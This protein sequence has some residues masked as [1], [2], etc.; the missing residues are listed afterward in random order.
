[1]ASAQVLRKQEH[2]EAGK[3]RLE[4]FRKKKA[5][6]QVKKAASVSQ[7]HTSDIRPHQKQPLE[8]EPVRRTDSDGAGTSDE[9]G[10]A[11]MGPS[12]AVTANENK[13]I[14][15]PFKSEQDSLNDTL[16]SPPLSV[17]YSNAHYAD[18]AQTD[19]GDKKFKTYGASGFA[20]SMDVN[21]SHETEGL[22]NDVGIYTGV[23]GKLP[24][25]TATDQSRFFGRDGSQSTENRSS[26]MQ[27]NVTNPGYS[28]DSTAKASPQNS[29]GT[30]RQANPSNASMLISAHTSSSFYEDSIQATSNARG[31]AH[32]T[33][34]HM[35]GISHIGDS[36]VSD[37]EE[38][39]LSSYASSLPS[40]NNAAPL[41]FEATGTLF[42]HTDPEK[43]SFMSNSSNTNNMDL[44]GSSAF[45]KPSV[46]SESMG[47]F[48]KLKTPNGPSVFDQSRNSS[49]YSGSGEDPVR[50]SI[51]ENNLDIKQEFY[52]AKQNEDFAALEQHIEDLTQEK[53]SLQRALEASQAL[54]E[55][56]ASEN[57]SATDSYNQQ[58]S[59]VNQLKSDMEKLQEE[60]KAQLVELESVKIE[61]SNA[62]LECNAADE[63]AKLL[64]AEVIG[65]EEKALRLRSSELKLERQLEKS[66]AEI[67]SY[68]KKMSSL[69][70]ERQDLQ[71]TIDALQEEKKL[72]QSKLRKA[73][74]SN[75]SL[76]K[77]DTSTST[78]DLEPS[79]HET[80]QTASS[81]GSDASSVSLLPENGQ[82]TLEVS[83]VNIPSDQMRMI[84]NINAIISELALEKEELMQALVSESS[85]CSK[86]KELN[87]DLSHKLES[88]TQRLEL[89]TA[90]SM[91][92]ESIQAR[93]PDSHTMQENTPY[94]DEG[95]EVVERV[96]G[97]IM[98]LFP[99]GPSRRR[100]SKLL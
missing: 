78:E 40:V 37:Y 54:A 4:E 29:V 76:N 63:R 50:W 79:I 14:G 46:E 64:A 38:R 26:L 10:K 80:H 56:L 36:M 18:S 48:P 72:L 60:I 20:R 13:A 42:Q 34:Q 1:M 41:T 93:Q 9:P 43:G 94:A 81:L 65:L 82:S 22:N 30:L 58:R 92:N 57:S 19:A 87:K 84:Q 99:G 89:L 67:S 39:K 7:N 5:A 66:Q 59:V 83:S 90:Q 17:K 71:S 91:A 61:Y 88:Q 55:S 74:T 6:E 69:E 8:T 28:H 47:T 68:R 25:E 97:W 45:K 31:S 62:Q 15:F 27:S 73:S 2:L 52:S 86:L 21:H 33:G 51:N 3:R 53:F 23:Q 35:N 49:V 12:A 85:H 100:T 70:K 75:T 16:A 24:F 11:V 96:L 77:R 98:K 95:D 44:F 32:E